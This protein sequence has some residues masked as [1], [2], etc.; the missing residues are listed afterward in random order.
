MIKFSIIEPKYYDFSIVVDQ[1]GKSTHP[2]DILCEHDPPRLK[3]FVG[4]R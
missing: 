3:K 1:A 4:E 2:M